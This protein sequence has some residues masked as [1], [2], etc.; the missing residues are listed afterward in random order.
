MVT[1]ALSRWS[2]E[3]SAAAEANA[4]A[5]HNLAN[6]HQ[7]IAEGRWFSIGVLIKR[8]TSSSTSL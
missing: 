6:R 3:A 2:A 8:R 4:C 1:V 5:S 7:L